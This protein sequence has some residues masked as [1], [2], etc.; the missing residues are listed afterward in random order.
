MIAI[1]VNTAGMDLT[2]PRLRMAADSRRELEDSSALRFFEVAVARTAETVYG[3]HRPNP[4]LR[5]LLLGVR[6]AAPGASWFGYVHADIVFTP[7][8]NDW[9]R[10]HEGRGRRVLATCRLNV[11]EAG[12]LAAVQA[13]RFGDEPDAGQGVGVE[14]MLVHAEVYGEFMNRLP[15]V[16]VGV[17]AWGLTLRAAAR[18]LNLHFC[19]SPEEAPLRH[20]AHADHPG[21]KD[22][23]VRQLNFLMLKA[24]RSKRGQSPNC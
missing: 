5:D 15:D 24:V 9:L 14:L 2:D 6:E 20:V 18:G 19:D 8:V 12:S 16:V 10:R 1:A 11:R 22:S 17:D 23:L 7:A 4:F 21:A 3:Y 13:T